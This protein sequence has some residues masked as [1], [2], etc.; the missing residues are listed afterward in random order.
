MF[1]YRNY[2]NTN[3]YIYM[4]YKLGHYV[5]AYETRFD[6]KSIFTYNKI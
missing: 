1:W 5:Y 3:I 2:H 4:A 6:R